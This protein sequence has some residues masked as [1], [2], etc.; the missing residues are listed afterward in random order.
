MLLYDR[1]KALVN[2]LVCQNVHKDLHITALVAHSKHQEN[3]NLP[4]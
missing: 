1:S 2:P 4:Y 3:H